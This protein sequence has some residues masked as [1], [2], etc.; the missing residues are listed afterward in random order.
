M[1][2]IAGALA[3]LHAHRIIHRDVKLANVLVAHHPHAALASLPPDHAPRTSDWFDTDSVQ[4]PP[5]TAK[6]CD[7]S[8]A[9][10]LPA[11][12]AAD[13]VCTTLCGTVNFMSP[14]IA[15]RQ[16]HTTATDLWSL[17]CVFYGL[18][19]GEA[20]FQA[21]SMERVLDRVLYEHVHLPAQV[22]H[23]SARSLFAALTTRNPKERIAAK[24][25]L[26]HSFC[27]LP[28]QPV[29]APTS[30][31][32]ADAE[33]S[34][35]SGLPLTTARLPAMEE[36]SKHTLLAIQPSG[37]ALL[38][39]LRGDG[40]I[41]EQL[42]VSGDGQEV[43]CLGR[44]SC[45]NLCAH[46][47]ENRLLGRGSAAGML[48]KVT[49]ITPTCHRQFAAAMH[50]WRA[51]SALC[52]RTRPRY[53]R[54]AERPA[55]L[56]VAY[57]SQV[58]AYDADLPIRC[59]LMERGLHYWK[60]RIRVPM[61]VH[62]SCDGPSHPVIVRMRVLPDGQL[63]EW[64]VHPPASGGDAVD[65]MDQ[66]QSALDGNE[67]LAR[68]VARAGRL[69]RKCRRLEETCMDFPVTLGRRWPVSTSAAPIQWPTRGDA[70]LQS[71][72]DVDARS[73]GSVRMGRSSLLGSASMLSGMSSASGARARFTFVHNLGWVLRC[74]IAKVIRQPSTTDIE[75]ADDRVETCG[76]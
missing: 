30:S 75:R 67:E 15:A 39:L 74:V 8:L 2:D 69:V 70:G 9:E 6:L 56:A 72:A 23:D 37:H 13:G 58:T 19:V 28:Q 17:G 14:E 32:I 46:G 12:A 7:F 64:A 5:Y 63:R 22:A 59:D 20:P 34:I 1:R 68:I 40:S 43:C 62:M 52:S 16:P 54:P 26:E 25:V 53:A 60:A 55:W 38:R 51:L 71:S 33:S 27:K 29:S 57:G 41:R 35:D 45:Q 73:S 49:I 10:S 48:L 21:S 11:S 4:P 66:A 42:V 76:F 65:S 36:R 50:S 3:Y 31:S 61:D 18:I 44:R 47:R 24:Q